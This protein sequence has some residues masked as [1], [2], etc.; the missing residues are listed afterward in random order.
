MVLLSTVQTQ[1]KMRCIVSY[2][3][4]ILKSTIRTGISGTGH[5][6]IFSLEAIDRVCTVNNMHR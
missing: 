2:E 6:V 5:N 4:P 1:M 3:L